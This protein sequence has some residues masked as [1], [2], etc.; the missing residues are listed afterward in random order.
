MQ[1]DGKE[2]R[3]IHPL[4]YYPGIIVASGIAG[5]TC[6]AVVGGGA[7]LLGARGEAVEVYTSVGGAFMFLSGLATGALERILK[8]SPS[9]IPEYPGGPDEDCD[10]ARST[11]SIPGQA[12]RM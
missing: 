10:N 2:Q 9:K 12:G 3:R 11:S 1:T 4:L 7:Y 8:R 5:L 6:A